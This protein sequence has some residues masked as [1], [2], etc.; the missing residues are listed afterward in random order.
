MF[1]IFF[2]SCVK[3]ALTPN[4]NPADVPVRQLIIYKQDI[5]YSIGDDIGLDAAS[6]R[7]M[8][9]RY[10]QTDRQTDT[11]THRQTESER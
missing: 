8:R 2:V 6:M 3:G 5:Q 10:R 4:Q 11:H 1:T 9:Q 7:I